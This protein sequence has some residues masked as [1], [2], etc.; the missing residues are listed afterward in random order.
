MLSLC[1]V[2]FLFLVVVRQ[3]CLHIWLCSGVATCF[4]MGALVASLLH[5]LACA[6]LHESIT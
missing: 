4:F 3:A 6:L 5:G 2:G 1:F